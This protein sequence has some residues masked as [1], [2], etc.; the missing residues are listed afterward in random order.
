M[1]ILHFVIGRSSLESPNGVDKTIFYLSR[2]QAALGAEVAAFCISPKPVIPIAGVDVRNF[3]ARPSPLRLPAAM[4]AALLE[5]KPD[6][7]HLHAPWVPPNLAMARFARRHRI[8]YVITAHGN[9]APRLLRRKPWFKLPY[10][11]L[12]ERPLFNRAAFVH[13]IADESAIRA[14]G[15][16]RPIVTAPN[17]FDLDDVE[18]AG[19]DDDLLT[20]FPGLRGKKLFLFLGRLDIEQK[21]LDVLLEAFAKVGVANSDCHLVLAGPSWKDGRPRLELLARQLGISERLTF[22]GV[23]QGP[24]KFALIREC[25]AFLHPSRWEAGVPFA[26][27][28]ALATGKPCIVSSAADPLGRLES[29]GAGIIANPQPESLASVMADL[30]SATPERLKAMSRAAKGLVESDFNWKRSAEIILN[31]C[32]TYSE[33]SRRGLE[34]AAR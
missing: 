23:V 30:A 1:R 27:M 8:P 20:T 13:A 15:V 18:P 25:H 22:C 34:E 33:C 11:Y 24:R 16:T 26:V 2:S 5:W 4:R 32:E 12:F 28:E 17:G 19:T 6:F 9:L 14:F 31:A 7:I 21:G 3:P 29:A 10:K